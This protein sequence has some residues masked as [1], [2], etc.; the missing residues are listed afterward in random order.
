MRRRE[1]I[2]ALGGTAAWPLAARAQQPAIPAIGYLDAGSFEA[3]RERI[4]ALQRGLFE[5][6][7]IEGRNV[8]IEYRWAEDHNDRLAALAAELVRRDVAVMIT[9]STAAA[10]VAKAATSTVPIVFYIGADP[11]KLGLV[12]SLN[13]PG[14]NVTGVTTLSNSVEV[15]KLELLH[16]LVPKASLIAML[17]NPT[18][19][20]TAIDTNDVT[21]ASL[22][23]GVDLLILNASQLGPVL[24]RRPFFQAA[25]TG[26]KARGGPGSM[27]PLSREPACDAGSKH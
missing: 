6:G 21:A 20:N 4:A 11:V 8:A 10:Q 7:F 2:F 14:G 17:F 3:R 25:L 27:V 13:R 23:S 1:F 24:L 5:N 9:Y 15:K 12:A 19:P 18:N 16:E 22:T 26:V